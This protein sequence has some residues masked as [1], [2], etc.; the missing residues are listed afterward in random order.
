[1]QRELEIAAL[2]D[3]PID[4]AQAFHRDFLPRARE[5]LDRGCE[6]LVIVLP[7]AAAAHDDWRRA[8]ARDLA[9]AYAPR[10]VNCL[11][12]GSADARKAMLA[13]LRAAP[14]ITGQYLPL[15]D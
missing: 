4:A 1:M 3:A 10:R 6:S 15:H 9:R 14:G 11:G 13:Y 7:P 8:I 5:M 2:P 12:G